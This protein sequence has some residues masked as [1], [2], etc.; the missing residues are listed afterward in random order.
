MTTSTWKMILAG[1]LFLSAAAS[2]ILHAQRPARS[3]RI[4]VAK[5]HPQY[6]AVEEHQRAQR[7]VLRRR[8][9]PTGDRELSQDE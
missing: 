1:A 3:H 9:N 7:L 6:F 2:A 5:V 8:G 4:E